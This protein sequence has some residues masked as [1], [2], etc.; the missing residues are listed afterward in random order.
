M[1]LS[2]LC[3]GRK[4]ECS[5]LEYFEYDEKLASLSED[6]VSAPASQAFIEQVFSVTGMQTCEGRNRMEKSLKYRV[7]LKLNS[8]NDDY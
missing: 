4:K 2:K 7:C 5:V 8:H 3:A 6:L 1:S